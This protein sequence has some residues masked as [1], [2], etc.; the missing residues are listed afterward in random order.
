MWG[1]ELAPSPR[2][3]RLPLA[4]LERVDERNRKA[5]DGAK[6]GHDDQHNHYEHRIIEHTFDGIMTPEPSQDHAAAAFIRKKDLTTR[7]PALC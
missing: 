2:R 4:P 7:H 5:R 1:G 3:I 6:R